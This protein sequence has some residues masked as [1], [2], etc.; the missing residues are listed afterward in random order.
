MEALARAGAGVFRVNLSHGTHEEHAAA[1]A[2]VRAAGEKLGVPL[3]VMVD[4]P[5]PKLRLGDVPAEV[6]LERGARVTLGEGADLPVNY[7][8]HVGFLRPG[9]RV[10]VDDG[11][12][13]LRVEA[14]ET[15]R[16]GAAPRAVL[17]VRDAGVVR[18][19]M[20]VNLPDT[21][22]TAP[23]LTAADREHIAFAVE[24][25][26]DLAALSFVRSAGDVEVLREALAVAGG[27]QLVVAK[28]EKRRALAELGGVVAAADAIMVARGDLGVEI[29]PAEV[30]LWQKRII[31]AGVRAGKP[32]VTAT[33]M[34]QSMI[35]S[36]R[37]TRAE[38][39]DVANAIFDSTCA[40]MLSG[41]TAVGAHAAEAVAT[42]ARIAETVEADI[43]REGRAPQAWARDPDDVSGAIS[44]GACDVARKVRAA[45]IVTATQSGATARAVAKYRPSQPII[46]VSPR[47]LTVRQLMLAWGVTPLLGDGVADAGG[48]VDGAV[49]RVR[50]AGLVGSGDTVVVTAGVGA[51]EPGSTD[52]IRVV[53]I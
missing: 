33:Q 49:A 45:A 40:V 18:A 30:P 53:T 36:P 25:E 35:E 44:S 8:E 37:P 3:A 4:L 21:D 1:V 27:E 24:H 20:G 10:L 22:V 17:E 52:L 11:A 28:I 41:E 43:E 32:V 13:G 19:R 14:V 9:E 51:G 50:R 42:M 26:V 39:S 31:H 5:G 29:P 48:V 6:E 38:A 46:A 23:V 12:V 7:P 47:R 16:P 34:L 2:D 15:A